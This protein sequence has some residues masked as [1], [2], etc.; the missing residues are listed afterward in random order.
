[1]KYAIIIICLLCASPAMAQTS[2]VTL[3]WT[4]PLTNVDD[5]PVDDLAG[6]RLYQR[7]DTNFTQMEDVVAVITN[8]VNPAPATNEE[9]TAELIL[10]D[11]AWFTVT[12][13]DGSGNE[14]AFALPL[15]VDLAAPS[16]PSG[17]KVAVKV[18]VTVT[19]TP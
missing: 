8:A 15:L 3:A 13:F 16:A 12:A 19:V 10:T 4:A 6:F 9:Y 5:T 7:A 2:Q 17:L 1:M 18:D 14:S 11:S